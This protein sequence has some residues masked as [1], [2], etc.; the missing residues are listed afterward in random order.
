M[1]EEVNQ[2]IN[3]STSPSGPNTLGDVSLSGRIL[4]ADIFHHDEE[5]LTLESHLH[6]VDEVLETLQK[7]I[8]AINEKVAALRNAGVEI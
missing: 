2:T 6:T 7:G 8:R 5:V 1:S 4:K 3:L